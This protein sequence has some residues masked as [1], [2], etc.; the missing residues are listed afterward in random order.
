MLAYI[1]MWWAHGDIFLLMRDMLTQLKMSWLNKR[2]VGSLKDG[3]G[4]VRDMVAHEDM[5]THLKMWA[6]LEMSW[7]IEMFRLEWR[8][9]GLYL[10]MR[11]LMESCSLK[12]R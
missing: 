7:L 1:E 10:G 4:S 8:C 6:H 2:C 3:I 5:L 9:G 12:W 11:W